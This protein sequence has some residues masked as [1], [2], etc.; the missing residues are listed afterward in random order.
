[1]SAAAATALH[2]HGQKRYADISFSSSSSSSSR[3]AAA[4][5][6][7]AAGA[8]DQPEWMTARPTKQIRYYAPLPKSVVAPVPT[9]LVSTYEDESEPILMT[10][11]YTRA[12][13]DIVWGYLDGPEEEDTDGAV[14]TREQRFARSAMRGGYNVFLTGKAGTGKT[15]VL[16][17]DIQRTRKDPFVFNTSPIGVAANVM[18]RGRTIHSWGFG[19]LGKAPVRDIIKS[20]KSKVKDRWLT[21]T[22]LRIDEIGFMSGPLLDKLDE[23]GRTLRHDPRPFG[24]IQVIMT[25]DPLQLPPVSTDGDVEPMF[26]ES[27]V[28]PRLCHYQLQL[29]VVKRQ[30]G[31]PAFLAALDELRDGHC[32]DETVRLLTATE[33]N[34]LTPPHGIVPT[35]LWS[36][37]VSVA[38]ANMEELAKLPGDDT[39]F[40]AI[41]HDIYASNYTHDRFVNCPAERELRLKVGAQVMCLRN[42]VVPGAANG[43]KGIVIGFDDEKK[44]GYPIVQFVNDVVLVVQP[45]EFE[46]ETETDGRGQSYVTVSRT[47][48][49]LKLAWN[50][51]MHKTL[52]ATIDYLIVM[53]KGIFEFAQLYVAVS[54]GRSLR[55]M[56][57]VGFD[58]EHVK[59]DPRAVN[60]MK[61]TFGVA[62]PLDPN[63]FMC[64]TA[65]AMWPMKGPTRYGDWRKALRNILGLGQWE[66]M[67]FA[68]AGKRME[69]SIGCDFEEMYDDIRLGPSGVIHSQPRF[70]QHPKLRFIGASG[71]RE[72][73]EANGKVIGGVEIKYRAG[74]RR[75][76]PVDLHTY[77]GDD[78]Y[79]DQCFTQMFVYGWTQN[80]LVAKS[81]V[82]M[83]YWPYKWLPEWW[84][85][86]TAPQIIP[87]YDAYLRWYWEGDRSP[88]AMAPVLKF[89]E[90][91][92][93]HVMAKITGLFD[94]HPSASDMAIMRAWRA[95]RNEIKRKKEVK[96]KE[97]ADCLAA[98]AQSL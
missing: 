85:K 40:P 50:V 32:S 77:G 1:M 84:I 43:T 21:A 56:R 18:E 20:L 59:A 13:V 87:K 5:A 67:P 3:S 63:R 49:P 51:T 68:E 57:I 90:E 52:G 66:K 60:W 92:G 79:R 24:G 46:V 15:F 47:Q 38:Q 74:A 31:D 35:K 7:I 36:L 98:Y 27:N 45:F 80:F 44:G 81:D 69:Y 2:P 28:W 76:K 91:E 61:R 10:S 23:I 8:P 39:V 64:I 73:K 29:T 94:R 89:I 70:Q 97:V 26:F 41:D 72:L 96:A 22:K 17:R 83:D 82:N 11:L 65:S 53:C 14:L 6:T 42:D 48:I 88:E 30:A 95:E 33:S 4:A 62:P 55:T 78:T 86:E 34:V 25:G 58:R 16:H 19:G 71:D 37:R 54:R 93:L 12:N 75:L 9:A